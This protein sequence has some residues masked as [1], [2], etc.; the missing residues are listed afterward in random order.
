MGKF[1]TATCFG[2][3]ALVA[4]M[5]GALWVYTSPSTVVLVTAG[6]L[7]IS[8]CATGLL[9]RRTFAQKKLIIENQRRAEE[10][11]K[12]DGL[13]IDPRVAVVDQAAR[14]LELRE[15]EAVVL[16]MIAADRDT[17]E[18]LQR[19]TGLLARQY[20]GARF[21]VV[22]DDLFDHEPID[23]GWSILRR[24][25]TEVGW[26]LQAI[27]RDG[28][29]PEEQVIDVAIDLARLAIG[30]A[31]HQSTLRYQAD[32]D[33]LT[34]L[35][36]RR[37]VLS[38][39]DLAIESNESVGLV[40]CDVDK[41][42]EINDTLGHQIGDELLIAISGRL[43][44]A[45]EEVDF[46]CEPGRLGGDEF[47]LVATGASQRDLKGFVERLSFAMQAPF[48]FEST[49][50]STSLS[51][52][53]SFTQTRTENAEAPDPT[54]LLRESDLALYQVKRSGRNGFRFFDSELRAIDAA[55]KE[56]A[57]DLRQSISNRSGLHAVYQPQ[58]DAHGELVGFEALARWT[59]QGD[60][61]ESPE[62]FIPIA[63]ER[64]L[65]AQFD[66]EIFR[67]TIQS[68][69]SMRR[70]GRAYGSVA[71]NV[72]AERLEDPKFV[73]GTIDVLRRASID[74]KTVVLEITESSLL[75]DLRERGRR[76]EQLRA[77]GVRIAIDDFG[78]GYSS[79]SYLRDLPVDIVK[80]DKEF[81][82]DIDESE[83]SQAIVKAILTLSRA[84]DL[85][86]VAEGIERQSQFDILAEFGGDI[87]Q[88]YM[89][90]KP[91]SAEDMKDLA[92]K[93]WLPDPFEAGFTFPAVPP[94]PEVI[95]RSFSFRQS[96][97]RNAA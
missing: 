61:V 86:V 23:M 29:V 40:Y 82:S 69:A 42:K 51:I 67:H 76:L 1:A 26:V 33:A 81:V 37:A 89:L 12:N 39:L 78:T 64:G 56:L 38:V 17:K 72:S 36:S 97:S 50:V 44:E 85:Q 70:E 3:V 47:L 75:H 90:G 84:L 95:E 14:A 52:G 83:L 19:I 13:R 5:V 66:K 24:T 43:T 88:G 54:E 15:D 41:F 71:V 31:R 20:P 30:K 10:L 4:A 2:A 25:E 28:P 22:N 57:E 18:I 16:E 92:A 63:V 79:L 80:L 77:W 45:A 58:F 87:F 21:R 91:L 96:G 11:L 73:E 32:H 60:G 7:A 48:R 27:L 49:T 34:G 94:N 68:M 59:R 62:T 55:D 74:P 93:K 53:A 46:N 8:L 65:M 35:L 6:L 9:I